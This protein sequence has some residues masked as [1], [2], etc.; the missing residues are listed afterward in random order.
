MLKYLTGY[1]FIAL[2]VFVFV[3]LAA[4]TWEPL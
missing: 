3:L 1:R 4:V 2:Y